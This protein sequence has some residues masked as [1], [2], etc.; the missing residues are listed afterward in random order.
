MHLFCNRL[1]TRQHR[2][3]VVLE[4]YQIGHSGDRLLAQLTDRG[5]P[6][7]ECA[8]GVHRSLRQWSTR[9]RDTAPLLHPKAVGQ[10]REDMGDALYV[11]TSKGEAG[12]A[13]VDRKV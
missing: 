8:A 12:A 2:W 4:S 11:N 10:V 9:V 7:H 13:Y 1:D 5:W 6:P 3:Y